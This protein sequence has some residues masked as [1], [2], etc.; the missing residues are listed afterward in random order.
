[1][2]KKLSKKEKKKLKYMQE[3][4]PQ[5][6]KT[7]PKKINI[8]KI[9]P[10]VITTF[11]IIA[12]VL[13]TRTEKPEYT[14]LKTDVPFVGNPDAPVTIKSFSEFQCPYCADFFAKTYPEIK[15]KYIDTGKVKF[16]FYELPIEQRAFSFKASEAARCAYD[17]GKYEDYALLLYNK[18][19]HWGRIGPSVFDDYATEL[20]LDVEKFNTC[21]KSGSMKEIILKEIQDSKQFQITG[22]PTFFINDRR[23]VGSKPF[24]DFEKIINEKLQL[25]NKTA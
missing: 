3:Q 20:G 14:P 13:L 8:K 9:I 7:E 10:F 16:V 15:E 6:T 18:Q 12:I 17:Q 24:E 21:L 22:T 5:P 25:A 4:L 23:I 2:G 19:K 11:L 1:M